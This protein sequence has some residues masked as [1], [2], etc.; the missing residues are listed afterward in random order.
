MS[1]PN[2]WAK[3][4]TTAKNPAV[5]KGLMGASADVPE[6]PVNALAPQQQPQNQNALA[7]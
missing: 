7:R 1:D 6:M 5:S 3:I 2:T 4:H